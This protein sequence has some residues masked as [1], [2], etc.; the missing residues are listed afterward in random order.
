MCG[1]NKLEPR[2]SIFGHDNPT[3]KPH[4]LSFRTG[5]HVSNSPILFLAD[6]CPPIGNVTSG[7]FDETIHG[8]GS[9]VG[10]VARLTCPSYSEIHGAATVK[11][12]NGAWDF[13]NGE[14]TICHCK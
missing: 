13:A 14:A 1:I 2:L 12:V 9:Q 6:V 8:D 11:C 4:G 7:V 10:S 5:R 3:A